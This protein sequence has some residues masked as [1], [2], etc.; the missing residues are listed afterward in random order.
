[1]SRHAAQAAPTG[2][3]G[4]AYREPVRLYVYGV[5][6]AVVALL[7]YRGVVSGAESLLWLALA[8]AVLVVPATEAARGR[9]AS[10][11][12]QDQL[13]RELVDV[14][15][16]AAAARQVGG[17]PPPEPPSWYSGDPRAGS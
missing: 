16:D 5:L 13:E 1:M 9:V 7:V 12:T 3:A 15:A 6:V 17:Y 11:A 4:L 14:R 8:Q 2:L 10:P